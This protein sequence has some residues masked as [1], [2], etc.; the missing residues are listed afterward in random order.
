[1]YFGGECQILEQNSS[2]NTTRMML[3]NAMD[4]FTSE[5]AMLAKSFILM[6]N[7]FVILNE[8]NVVKMHNQ[9]PT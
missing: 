2:K 8:G 3:L 4:R 9:E 6:F 7:S 5:R 1:M